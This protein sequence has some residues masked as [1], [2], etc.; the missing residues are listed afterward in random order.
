MQLTPHQ[1]IISKGDCLFMRDLMFEM[2]FM[3]HPKKLCNTCIIQKNYATHASSEKIM[4]H[5]RDIGDTY[6][7]NACSKK[8]MRS[9]RDSVRSVLLMRDFD[10]SQV[11]RQC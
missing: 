8:R 4:Q 5:M 7:V 10:E 1:M 6:S 11:M 3:H 9:M 2:L